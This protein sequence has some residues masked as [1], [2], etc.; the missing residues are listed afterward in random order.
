MSSKLSRINSVSSIM[1]TSLLLMSSMAGMQLVGTAAAA[2]PTNPTVLTQTT[3]LGVSPLAS[4]SSGVANPTS[5]DWT[6]DTGPG[7]TGTQGWN[8]SPQTQINS[9]SISSLSTSYLF[10]VPSI[11]DTVPAWGP[12]SYVNG[13]APCR[14]PGLQYSLSLEGSQAPVLSSSGVGYITTN[15]LSVY[16][17]DLS[18]GKLL[19]TDLPSMDW[20]TYAKSPVNP[21]GSPGHLHGV[22]MVDGI[23]WV[24]GFGCQIQGWDATSGVLRANLT[25][26]CNNIPG[27]KSPFSG[28][29]AVLQL[30]RQPNPG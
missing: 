26:L 17:I 1:I 15:G 23:V 20:G 14:F 29:G 27:D 13:T 11:W 3:P 19:S 7:V 6:E 9:S 18:T 5:L 16:A 30:R 8:Y 28:V 25:G 22:N 21:G 12:C 4:G 2:T 24:P 10:P